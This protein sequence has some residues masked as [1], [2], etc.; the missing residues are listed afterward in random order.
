[1]GNFFAMLRQFPAGISEAARHP[2]VVDDGL[3]RSGAPYVDKQTAEWA[4]LTD[5]RVQAAVAEARVELAS[6][7]IFRHTQRPAKCRAPAGRRRAEIAKQAKQGHLH[8][9]AEV[10]GRFRRIGWNGTPYRAGGRGLHG[11]RHGLR[12]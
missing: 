11:L 9:P 10:A 6:H 4:V 12:R 8:V 5:R 7:A 1:M 2:V 3:R